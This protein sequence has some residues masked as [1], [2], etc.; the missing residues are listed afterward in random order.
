MKIA[1]ITAQT[2]FGRQE[3][4]ILTEIA[5]AIKL[6]AKI[7][8]IPRNPSREVF[9]DQAKPLVE[10]TLHLPLIN[11]NILLVFIKKLVTKPRIWK[12]FWCIFTHSRSF[13]ILAKNLAVLPKATFIAPQ[14]IKSNVKHIHAHWASTTA[15][16]AWVIS[17]LSGIPWSF[18][19]HRWDIDENNMLRLKVEHASFARC[20]SEDGRKKVLEI[21]GEKYCDKVKILHL[22]VP[23]S[24]EKAASRRVDKKH[25]FTIACPANFVRVKGHKYLVE[26]CAEL[27]KRKLEF[28]SLLIGDGPLE[29]EIRD[30]IKQLGLEHIVKL[31][32]RLPHERLMQL[33][34][35]GAVDTVVLPSIETEEG[36]KEGIPVALM[37]AM[38]WR[39]PVITTDTGGT[40]EL[41]RDGAGIVVPQRDSVRLADAIQRLIE[42]REL[43]KQVAEVGQQRVCE[44]FN[45]LKNTKTLLE[46]IQENSC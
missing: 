44:Q 21:V 37:E 39:I 16:M 20:I 17:E 18:T 40:H 38:A 9:H 22:G 3:T 45:I 11:R 26:A 10:H 7:V 13:K 5:A 29:K 6:G 42:N 35:D 32:G 30:Q 4:F 2:P 25:P 14:L 43:A 15:T 41:V 31:T 24:D 33:Y 1:Y 8:I 34:S 46:W 19:L 27:V 12:I 23:I 36:E 28:Q